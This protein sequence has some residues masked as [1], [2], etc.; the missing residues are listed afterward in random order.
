VDFEFRERLGVT[1]TRV[2]PG[3]KK[4][5]KWISTFFFQI[6]HQADLKKSGFRVLTGKK[7]SKSGFRVPG[8]TRCNRSTKFD[9]LS[10]CDRNGVRYEMIKKYM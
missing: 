5:E 7:N 1:D 9:V 3:S 4:L 8:K 6:H 2:F 10:A